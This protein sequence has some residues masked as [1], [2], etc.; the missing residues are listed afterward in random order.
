[1]LANC[2][3]LTVFLTAAIFSTIVLTR[4]EKNSKLI[5]VLLL[6]LCVASSL[7]FAII[8]AAAIAVKIL[9]MT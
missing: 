5:D 7:F 3:A 6:L 1:M 9:K 8:E 2:I 4:M